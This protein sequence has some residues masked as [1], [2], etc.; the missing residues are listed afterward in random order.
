[1]QGISFVVTIFP[2]IYQGS[3][4]TSE[5]LTWENHGIFNFVI[6]CMINEHLMPRLCYEYKMSNARET[7]SNSAQKMFGI[8]NFKRLEVQ[9]MCE[10]NIPSHENKKKEH[11]KVRLADVDGT[12]TGCTSRAFRAIIVCI[13]SLFFFFLLPDCILLWQLLSNWSCWRG[14]LIAA[15]PCDFEF[16]FDEAVMLYE[17]PQR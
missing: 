8:W 11:W 9:I 10:R 13:P 2:N 5:I 15:A 14:K 1:M 6:K 3:S 17:C 16:R 7:A 12:C 4:P